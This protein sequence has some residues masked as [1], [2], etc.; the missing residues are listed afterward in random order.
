MCRSFKKWQTLYTRKVIIHLFPKI[1]WDK[2]L[3]SI[4]QSIKVV[5]H[6]DNVNFN[7]S[8]QNNR[9]ECTTVMETPCIRNN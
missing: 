8:K 3:K 5:C 2:I 6:N 9:F 1:I 7:K 4:H